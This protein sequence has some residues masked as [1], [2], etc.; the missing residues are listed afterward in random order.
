[1]G[2]QRMELWWRN[3]LENFHLLTP[4]RYSNNIKMG[5]KEVCC[6]DGTYI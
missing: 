1:M 6:E 4:R 2:S 5:L 3:I